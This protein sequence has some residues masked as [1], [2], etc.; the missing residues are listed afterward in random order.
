MSLEASRREDKVPQ[1]EE[2]AV[3]GLRGNRDHGGCKNFGSVREQNAGERGTQ[4][5]GLG[6]LCLTLSQRQW[7]APEKH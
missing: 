3:A 4:V 5:P 6:D 1:M 7:G 2:T